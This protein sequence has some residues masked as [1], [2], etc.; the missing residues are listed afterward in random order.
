[1]SLE[2]SL[3]KSHVEVDEPPELD[4]VITLE[5]SHREEVVNT[6]LSYKD[7]YT[8]NGASIE[9]FFDHLDKYLDPNNRTKNLFGY[10]DQSGMLQ[11]FLGIHFWPSLPYSTV[12]YMFVRKVEKAFNTKNNGLVFCLHKALR[13]GELNGIKAHYSVQRYRGIKHK[14]RSWRAFDT[15]LTKKYYSTLELVV[16]KNTKSKYSIVQELLDDR[17]WPYDL[18]VWCGRLKPEYEKVVHK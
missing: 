3:M 14:E 7:Q 15:Q 18:G 6:V 2:K 1:M 16:P 10:V 8:K 4:S 17:V 12:N 11:S 5:S 9:V 13:H